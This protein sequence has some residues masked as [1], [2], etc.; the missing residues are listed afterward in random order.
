MDKPLL[1]GTECLYIHQFYAMAS[2]FS[3][4]LVG[5]KKKYLRQVGRQ[6]EEIVRQKEQ[7]LSKY[8]PASELWRINREAT[9]RPVQ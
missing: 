5:T 9:K 1:N 8:S 7:L 6:M 3:L 4:H 2:P